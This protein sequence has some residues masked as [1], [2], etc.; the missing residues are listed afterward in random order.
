MLSQDW[1]TVE[2]S[3]MQLTLLLTVRMPFL[4][5]NQQRQSIDGCAGFMHK[6][7][8]ETDR[9]KCPIKLM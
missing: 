4:W 6:N 1:N 3:I 5:P 7:Q 2:Y 9:S 8:Y